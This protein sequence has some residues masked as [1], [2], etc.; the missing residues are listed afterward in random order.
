[1]V[2]DRTA[3][4]VLTIDRFALNF[5]RHWL[6]YVNLLF[7]IFVL[8]PFAAPIFMRIGATSMADAIYFVYSFL[9]HQLPQRS[10]FLF[11]FKISYSLAEI[12]NVWYYGDNILYLRQFIGNSAMGWKVAWS[13]RMISMYGALWVGGVLY[14]LLRKNLPR[15]SPMAWLLLALVPMGLDGFSHMVNDAVAGI[16]GTGFRDTNAWLQFLTGN[17]FPADF[18]AGDALGSFNSLARLLTGV[19]FGLTTIWLIYPFVDVAMQDLVHQAQSK[20]AAPR[21]V[22]LGFSQPEGK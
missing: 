18:Y 13:D 12:E 14:A 22:A 21:A 15:L 11:G 20:L 16:S 3:K 2:S 5:T 19:L 10:Y 6:L 9:C 7:G 1:M 17:I 8:A 4:L